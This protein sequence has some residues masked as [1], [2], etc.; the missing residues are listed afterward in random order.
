MVREECGPGAR[1]LH[2]ARIGHV[3]PMIIAQISTLR[4]KL[5]N[6]LESRGHKSNGVFKYV[7]AIVSTLSLERR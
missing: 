6:N 2:L 7:H 3:A 4:K 1:S 5:L